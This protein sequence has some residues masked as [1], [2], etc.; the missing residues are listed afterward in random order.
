MTTYTPRRTAPGE[1]PALKPGEV[2]EWRNWI[3]VA[4]ARMVDETRI[5]MRRQD[6]IEVI[7]HG[8]TV[9]RDEIV[10]LQQQVAAHFAAPAPHIAAGRSEP[11]S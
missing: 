10:A 2:D 7:A 1:P 11:G 4:S 8:V 3:L 6:H 9:L 5:R